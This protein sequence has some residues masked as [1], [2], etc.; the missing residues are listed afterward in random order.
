MF[1]SLL[2][3]KR[4]ELRSACSCELAKQSRSLPPLNPPPVC[5]QLRDEVEVKTSRTLEVPA[6]VPR[7][8]CGLELW[9]ILKLMSEHITL[10]N[11][12]ANDYEP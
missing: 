12:V 8:A 7:T 3:R 9:Q 5:S 1:S 10:L 11:L 4:L 2:R 6:L